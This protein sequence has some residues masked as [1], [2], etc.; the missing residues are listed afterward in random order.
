MAYSFL[1]EDN[2]RWAASLRD[3]AER[4]YGQTELTKMN[5]TDTD[6]QV[7]DNSIV[8]DCT[9]HGEL[10]VGKNS[11]VRGLFVESGC[12]VTVGDGCQIYDV[13]VQNINTSSDDNPEALQPVEFKDRCT[14]IRSDIAYNSSI[15][16]DSFVFHS[17]LGAGVVGPRCIIILTTVCRDFVFEQNVLLFY[18]VFDVELKNAPV[19][20]GSG[21]VFSICT[22]TRRDELEKEK[23]ESNVH[24]PMYRLPRFAHMTL[25]VRIRAAQAFIG[26]DLSVNSNIDLVSYEDVRIGN[27]VRILSCSDTVCAFAVR[28]RSIRIGNDVEV[29]CM[30]SRDQPVASMWNR[31][32]SLISGLSLGDGTQVLYTPG[33]MDLSHSKLL[34]RKNQ[35]IGM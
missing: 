6:I 23:L 9:V 7:G 17:D 27:N 4:I 25:S 33:F 34:S 2:R 5:V 28:G 24:I 3:A 22:K 14:V 31:A 20:F 30:T 16:E 32:P 10:I 13:R 1:Q 35:V 21:S 12:R 26:K 18:C 29:A 19:V 8:A 15:G 11:V